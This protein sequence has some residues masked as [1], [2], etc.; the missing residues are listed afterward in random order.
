MKSRSFSIIVIFVA[1][2]IVGCA[3]IP[4]LPVKLMPSRTLPSLSVS[5]SMPNSAARVVE[6][7][8]TSRLE[9]LLAR[10]VGVKE[11]KSTSSNGGGHITIGFDKHTDMQQ[12]RF[13]ASTIIRQ[14]WQELPDGVSYP[15]VTAARSID[16]S[17]RP[18]L[19]Y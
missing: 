9:G 15:T 3:L 16:Q 17:A 11:I 7:E 2:A 1:L 14:A 10:I 4:R 6:S 12:A 18:I 19:S 8:V 13:E 5:F